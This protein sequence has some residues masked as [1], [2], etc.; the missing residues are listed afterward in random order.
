MTETHTY[1]PKSPGPEQVNPGTCGDDR[2]TAD[3]PPSTSVRLQHTS[4]ILL[5][6]QKFPGPARSGV[7]SAGVVV[8]ASATHVEK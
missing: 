6:I 7:G 8:F 1:K 4:S 3:S 2:S 5:P